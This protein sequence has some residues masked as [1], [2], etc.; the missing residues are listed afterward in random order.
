[1]RLVAAIFDGF[2]SLFQSE[3]P[4]GGL[5]VVFGAN[6]SGKSNALEGVRVV[7]EQ[8]RGDTKHALAHQRVDPGADYKDHVVAGGVIVE[9]PNCDIE[10][11]LDEEILQAIRLGGTKEPREGPMPERETS[12]AGLPPFLLPLFVP[13]PLVWAPP[14]FADVPGFREFWDSVRQ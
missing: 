3:L 2:K 8:I 7:L 10:G 5:T 4:L 9:L 11:H 6:G 14:A 13:V 12:M 1:M